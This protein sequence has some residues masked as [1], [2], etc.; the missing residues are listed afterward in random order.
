[1]IEI[2]T[3]GACKGNPGP[4]GYGVIIFKDNILVNAIQQQ[5][6]YTTNNKMEL[7]AILHALAIINN[8]YFLEKCIIYSDSSYCVNIANDWIYTWAKNN[9]MNSKQQQIENI[10]LVQNLYSYVNG[11]CKFTIQKIKGHSGL[12][13]NELA[14]AAARC[15]LTDFTKILEKN[16]VQYENLNFKEIFD[17]IK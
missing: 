1:M 13:G 14:D 17:I 12:I 10:D 7:S 6:D 11:F 5:F 16:E 3:D 4:G 2:Y 9:W 15:N 8:D